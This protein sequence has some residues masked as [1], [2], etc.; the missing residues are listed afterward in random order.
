MVNILLFILSVVLA[1][2][3]LPSVFIFGVSNSWERVLI[4]LGIFSLS[5][6]KLDTCM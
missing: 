5:R 1:K 4:C 6:H 3:Y 2:I